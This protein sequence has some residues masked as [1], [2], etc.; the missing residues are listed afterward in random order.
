VVPRTS[1]E[2]DD[3]SG[4]RLAMVPSGVTLG[5]LVNGLNA[6]GVGPRDLIT[7][8]QAIKAAGA[9]QADIEIM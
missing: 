3:Q 1:I 9:L 6:L 8:L 2:V 4:R 7:I 5:E